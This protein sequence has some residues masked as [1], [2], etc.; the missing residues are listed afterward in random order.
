MGLL[1][2]AFWIGYV[3]TMLWLPR[4]AD[5]YG[6]KKIFTYGLTLSAVLYAALIFSKNFYLTMF[7]IFLFG[8]T[9]TVRTIMGFVYFTEMMPKKSITLATTVLWIIDGCVYLFVV[10]YFW[11]IS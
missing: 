7:I 4:M 9:N 2:T 1:G 8:V 10:V 3:S 6:R 11:K 5:V